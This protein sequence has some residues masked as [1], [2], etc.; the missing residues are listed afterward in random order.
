MI[1]IDDAGSG[2]LIGGTGI[3]VL[4]VETNEFYFDIIPLPY[5]QPPLFQQKKYQEYVI[6]I[7][8]EA[9]HK[10][11]VSKDESI[12]ICRGYMF[13]SLRCW[14][15]DH[16]YRW[17]STTIEGVLQ[18]KVEESFNQYVINLGLPDNF[19]KHARYAFGF[20]RLLK[21]VFA[22]LENRK[23]LC[24]TGWK[25]WQKW[26]LIQRSMFLNEAKKK[27]YCLKCGHIIEPKEPVMTVEYCTNKFW[28][29]N[30]HASCFTDNLT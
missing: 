8:Q 21:W 13:D 17:T 25:S 11:C 27:E 10:L 3:G 12:E 19:V 6:N 16:G 1:Q 15:S 26:S 2:S 24:K 29:I 18:E 20:H 7:I 23:A 30:V 4:R 9:F 14:L 22:D 28:S 5:Y